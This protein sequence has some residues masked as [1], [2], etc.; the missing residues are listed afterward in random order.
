MGVALLDWYEHGADPA[1]YPDKAADANEG[2]NL[3]VITKAKKILRYVDAHPYEVEDSTYADGSG[4]PF[5]MMA[6]RLGKSAAEAV[7]LT[8]EFDLTCGNGIDILEHGKRGSA[9]HR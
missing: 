3:L 2:A 8:C 1:D 4:R 6:L 9:K 5:A 7:A